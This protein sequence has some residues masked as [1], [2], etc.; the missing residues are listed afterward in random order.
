MTN[1][2]RKREYDE[3]DDRAVGDSASEEDDDQDN[4]MSGNFM[5][6]V[7]LNKFPDYPHPASKILDEIN[8]E[9]LPDNFFGIAYGARRTGKTH[10]ISC[11]LD[12]IKDRF[13]FAY[14]FS[15]TAGLHEGQEGELD[16]DMIRPEAKFK[17]FDEEALAMIIERQKKV[18]EHN[19]KCKNKRD[20]KPNRTLIIFDDFVHEKAVRYSKIFTELPVLGRHYGLSVIC[21]SQGYS[22]VGSSGLNP[23]TRQN[24]DFTLTFLPRNTDDI[25][26]IAKW[27]ISR[28]KVE[29]MWFIQSVCQEEHT[30]LGMSL[31]HPHL[32]DLEDY[33]FKYRAPKDVPKYE[34]GKVQ[35]KLF[36]EERKRNRK[37]AMMASVEND[38]AYFL[39]RDEVQKRMQIGEATG[40]QTNRTRPSLFD[41]CAGGM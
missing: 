40:M 35:W 29:A 20:M 15:A 1:G 33:C 37:A 8:F 3:D 21:L 4:T 12:P 2:K 26:R 22:A 17:G 34:L 11:L 5:D 39:S 9:D 27:Y 41:A 24:S 16:F 38:R 10:A 14:L 32:V 19:N 25:E 31:T 18:M 7:S 13:D 28:P 23:A 30:C 6:G 36:K